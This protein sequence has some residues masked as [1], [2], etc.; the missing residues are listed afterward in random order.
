MPLRVHSVMEAATDQWPT[1]VGNALSAGEPEEGQCS[2]YAERS[3][4][5]CP[6]EVTP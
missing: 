1:S 2:P 4:R 5:G 3:W 6:E